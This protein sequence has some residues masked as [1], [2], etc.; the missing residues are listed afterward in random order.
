MKNSLITIALLSQFVFVLSYANT[1]VDTQDTY[2]NYD[3]YVKD[4]DINIV[5][6]QYYVLSYTWAP[7]YCLSVSNENKKPGNKDYLQCGS[8]AQFGY[9]LHGLWPQGA[10]DKTGGYPRACEGDQDKIDRRILEKYLC[11]T[12]SVWLLQHEYEYH[13]TCMHDESLEDPKAYFDKAME[14]HSKLT[15]PENK[16]KYNDAGVNWFVDNNSHHNFDS[17]QYYQGGQEWQFC[18]DNNF[19]VMNCPGKSTTPDIN[20]LSDCKIKGNISNNSG[21]KYYFSSLHPNYSSVVITQSKGEKCF[22]TEQ[23]AINAGW[24]KAP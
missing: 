16:L 23:E 24:V 8:G 22:L 18:Y 14:L 6:S 3:D 11:M 5:N 9:V 2:S 13:G 19:K 12:P 7:G 15:F 20:P 1:C 21:K 4:S 10:L 17:I